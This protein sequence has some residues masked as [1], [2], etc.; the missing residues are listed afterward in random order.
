[1]AAGLAQIGE[2]SFI[3]GTVG[4][5][6]GLLPLEGIQLIVAGALA[7]IAVNPSSSAW[8]SWWRHSPADTGWIRP[9]SSVNAGGLGKLPSARGGEPLRLHAILAGYGRV[10][11]M[12]ATGIERR[13]YHYVVI[14]QDRRAR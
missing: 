3:L 14:S 6:L 2:F 13:G 1:M 10:G 12:I 11:R 5:S 4:L 9:C 8:S 7:S